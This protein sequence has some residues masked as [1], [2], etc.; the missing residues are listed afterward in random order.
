MSLKKN[1]VILINNINLSIAL[2]Y[3]QKHS[4]V[5]SFSVY[6]NTLFVQYTKYIWMI[7]LWYHKI[8]F[9]ESATTIGFFKILIEWH[10]SG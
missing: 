5:E 3:S 1:Q 10:S 8:F 7:N 2:A 9:S 6:S 4:A